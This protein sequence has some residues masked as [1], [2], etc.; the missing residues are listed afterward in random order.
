MDS[1]EN[2]NGNTSID[3]T[4]KLDFDVIL[5]KGKKTL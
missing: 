2:N 5:E 3:K 1:S 4:A